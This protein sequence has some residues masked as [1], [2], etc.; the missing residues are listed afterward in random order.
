MARFRQPCDS[1]RAA[2]VLQKLTRTIGAGRDMDESASDGGFGRTSPMQ[3]G[4]A[5]RRPATA[6]GGRMNDVIDDD[7]PF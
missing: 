3:R 1:R 2:K 5:D 7:I 6:G 4:G